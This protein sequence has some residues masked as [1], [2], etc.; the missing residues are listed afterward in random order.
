MTSQEQF[1][2]RHNSTGTH[3]SI[4]RECLATVRHLVQKK[5]SLAGFE[6]R[7]LCDPVRIYQLNQGWVART[8]IS[9]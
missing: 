3:D 4:C 7:H 5:R 1:S 6:L 2:H 9:S 8:A